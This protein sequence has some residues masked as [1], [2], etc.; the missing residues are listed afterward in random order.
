MA[1][2]DLRVVVEAW[3]GVA[4]PLSK[5]QE[6]QLELE[7]QEFIS[8]MRAEGQT[9]AEKQ[10][11]LA[12]AKGHWSIINLGALRG[13][14]R[15][16]R[17]TVVHAVE[18]KQGAYLATY[19]GDNAIPVGC[20]AHENKVTLCGKSENVKA[21]S[22]GWSIVDSKVSCPVCLKKLGNALK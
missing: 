6:Q 13:E 15:I 4:A 14:G 21:R 20:V 19:L 5:E 16:P 2:V 17:N 9:R 11:E 8:R 22:Q 7:R 10:M 12:A 1:S 18:F 3:S